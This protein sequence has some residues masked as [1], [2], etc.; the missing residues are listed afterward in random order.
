MKLK[1][2]FEEELSFIF[3][4][5]ALIWQIFFT[6]VPL[7]GILFV[8]FSEPSLKGGYF[9]YTFTFAHYKE[10]LDTTYITIIFNSLI[11]ASLTTTTCLFIAF[12]VAYFIAIKIQKY[13]TIFLFAL[14]LPS[15]TNFIV[16]IYAWFFLLEK[17]GLFSQII[18][19]LGILSYLPNFLNTYFATWIGMVY[20]FLPFMIFPIYTVLEKMDKRLLEASADLGAGRFNTLRRV[21]IPLAMPGIYVGCVLVFVP[22]FAEFVIPVL[23]GGS[24]NV[25]WGSVIVQKILI[26]RDWASGF[27]L[28]CLGVFLLISLFSGLFFIRWIYKFL[29]SKAEKESEEESNEFIDYW[30]ENG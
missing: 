10:L 24:R 15:W 14:I 27:A 5:P 19:K 28:A 9:P 29:T 13:R 12:P 23:L 21:I 20:C 1:R 4:S 6:Y 18:Y 8:S 30:D 16:Q 25:Y 17:G 2:I 3:S 11:L 22:S 7:I 26:A